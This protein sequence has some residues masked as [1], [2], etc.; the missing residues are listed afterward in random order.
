MPSYSNIFLF[1]FNMLYDFWPLPR[2]AMQK[3]HGSVLV[4]STTFR[5]HSIKL[6]GLAAQFEGNLDQTRQARPAAP[7]RN[8]CRQK[9]QKNW[10]AN[11]T[12]FGT[13][14]RSWVPRALTRAA[15]R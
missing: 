5:R 15:A 8:P 7:K 10:M 2:I 9:P 4:K 13:N 1:Y 3:N 11:R 14:V 12:R 6:R